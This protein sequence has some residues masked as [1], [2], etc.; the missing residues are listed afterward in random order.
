MSK[1]QATFNSYLFNPVFW[2]IWDALHDPKI[3]RIL[4]RGGSSAG[5]TAGICDAL[6]MYQLEA[7]VSCLALRKHRVHVETTIKPSFE[8]S[9]GRRPEIRRYYTPMEGEIRVA[10]GA[11]TK[12]GGMDDPEKIKGLESYDILYYNELNQFEPEEWSEGDRRLRGRPNQKIL[13]DWNPISVSHWINKEILSQDEGWIDLPLDLP[14]YEEAYGALTRLQDGYAFKR[15]NKA[16]DTLWINVTY[17]DNFWIVGHPANVHPAAPGSQAFQDANPAKPVTL[18]EGMFVAADGNLYGYVDKAQLA[19]FERMRIRKPNEYRIYGMGQDG[20]QRTGG[21]LWKQFD[22]ERNTRDAPYQPGAVIHVTLD[23]NVVPYVT[24]SIWQA[25]DKREEEG[26]IELTQVHEIPARAP[27]NTAFKAALL[28]GKW[29]ESVEYKDIIVVHGD[30]AGRARTTVDDNGRSFFDKFIQTLE[31]ME[32][33]VINKVQRAAPAVALSCSFINDIYEGMIPGWRIVINKACTVSI[34]DY[35][36]LKEDPDGK[37][38]KE[39]VEDKTTQRRYQPY[40]H[41]SDAKRYLVIAMLQTL[42]DNYKKGSRRARI[43][44]APET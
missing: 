43:I 30:P 19:V 40:G 37:P 25:I 29:L 27:D 9:I 14:Y 8:L 5:K 31:R 15:I 22:E 4:V 18:E 7:A 26:V 20:I 17:R 38:L 35:N 1:P 23:S 16:G 44:S 34:E 11:E 10:N 12:Y 36:L 39:T 24:V 28:F 21:E 6:N 33:K 13:A 42:F 41:F 32:Y 3:R 2:H